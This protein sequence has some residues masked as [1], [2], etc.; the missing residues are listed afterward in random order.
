MR[1]L[2]AAGVPAW[3]TNDAGPH[4]KALCAP[5]D[6]PRVA[7]ALAAVTGITSTQVCAP[8]AAAAVVEEHEA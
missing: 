3:F 5:A 4:V 7:A 8:D 1:A 6:A 2:R